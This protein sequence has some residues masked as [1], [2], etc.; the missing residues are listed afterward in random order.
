MTFSFI[1]SPQGS[2]LT[3]ADLLTSALDQPMSAGSTFWESAKEGVNQSYGLG[4]LLR[5]FQTPGVAEDQNQDPGMFQSFETQQGTP[6]M[7]LANKTIPD[8]SLTEDQFK[9]SPAY[10]E[11]IPWQRGMTQ[12]RAEALASA[13]D[14]SKVREF[15]AQKRPVTAFM[16]S[17][18]GSAIDP[19]NYI[20][21][22]GEEVFAANVAR[23]GSVAGRALTSSADAMVNTALAA[24]V[25]APT[26]GD[27][28]DDISFQSTVSQIAMAAIVGGAFGAVHGSAV[29]G[30]GI[31]T[32]K[33]RL[34]IKSAADLRADAEVKLSTLQG[35]QEA[36]VALNDALDGMINKGEV[37][38]SP[39]SAAFVSRAADVE[40]PKVAI[41]RMAR[42]ADPE[43]FTRLDA[44]SQTEIQR[45]VSEFLTAK[46]SVYKLNPDGTTIRNKAA[47]ND[48]GHEGD[49]GMKPASAK[50][51]YIDGNA[52]VLSSAGLSGIGEKG[53][54]VI[55]KD[56]KAS[57][58]TWNKK[59]NRW[60]FSPES[61]DTVIHDEPAIGRYPLELWNEVSDIPGYQ[62]FSR[63]HAGNKIIEIK[64]QPQTLEILDQI[65]PAKQNLINPTDSKIYGKKQILPVIDN[66]VPKDAPDPAVVKAKSRVGKPEA[67][68]ALAEQY[69]VDPKTGDY[70]ELSDIEQ[71]RAEGRLTDDDIAALDDADENFKTATAY[72]EALKA[73][74]NCVI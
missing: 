30:R 54:R 43:M 41:A 46:G 45:P 17:L 32:I 60:G 2:A 49:S 40:M 66:S 56:G 55:I 50:T 68:R 13:S 71:L 64:T 21:V 34:G 48:V 19:I 67:D 62:A 69:H 72:G 58:L 74:G 42:D 1:P 23:F 61:R 6:W 11:N 12:E 70:P 3:G 44:L 7:D 8:G 29:F 51:V 47:R 5:D 65:G 26:R 10:R 20:P 9:S 36:R 28:G 35:V 37:E 38:I 27:L 57:L 39:A 33:D 52:S 73:F 15:Y 14:V 63:M 31:D 25:S 53:S 22:F 4:A 59:E 18:A 16:G 24:A